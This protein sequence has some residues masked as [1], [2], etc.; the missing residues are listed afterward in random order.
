MKIDPFYS[1]GLVIVTA[2]GLLAVAVSLHIGVLSLLFALFAWWTWQ[3]PE[4]ALRFFII[5]APLLPM[6]KATQ[7]VGTLTLTKDVI[8]IVLFARVVA[9]PL[10]TKTLPYR[11]N[12]LFAPLVALATWTAFAWLQADA[13]IL[14][15]LRARDISLYALLYFVVLYLPHSRQLMKERWQWFCASAGVVYLLAWYQWF[16]A[17]DSAVL[18]FDPVHSIW[19]P[20]VSSTFAHPS[21]FGEYL[22]LLTTLATSALITFKGKI[23]WLSIGTMTALLPLVYLTYSR[24]VWLG[25]LGAWISMGIALALPTIREH[26]NPAFLS[27]FLASVIGLVLLLVLVVVFTPAGVFLRSSLDSRY[28][29]NAIRLDFAVRL[30][31]PLTNTQALI[32]RGLGDVTT[33]TFRSK[34]GSTVDVSHPSSRSVQ[35]SKDSTLVDNQYL[36]TFVEM[37]LVG[38]LIYAWIYGRLFKAA[39]GKNMVGLWFAGFLTAFI[40][41]ALFVDIWDVFPTNA[42]F[43]IMAGLLS[44]YA[45]TTTLHSLPVD[46]L[47]EA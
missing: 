3:N 16:F 40:I 37:G 41:Q 13:V 14:G 34:E 15:A 21:V 19:I 2:C 5:I 17:I 36:K 42:L 29:S 46:L 27:R 45:T 44:A 4:M 33:Q 22:I 1:W 18:R 23:R 20:R 6:F 31:A 39:I 30:I 25:L 28:S 26:F 47:F 9:W 7:S 10:L 11:R 24:G 35:L 12:I 43:W 8:I 32:G 38:L